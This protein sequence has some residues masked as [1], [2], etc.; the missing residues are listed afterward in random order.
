MAVDINIIFPCCRIHQPQDAAR[1]MRRDSRHQAET[2]LASSNRPRSAGI[3]QVMRWMGLVLINNSAKAMARENM[4]VLGTEQRR[5]TFVSQWLL[6]CL[7][8]YF[9]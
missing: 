5:I 2:T 9:D 7:M 3:F 4:L 6:E 1:S 8:K